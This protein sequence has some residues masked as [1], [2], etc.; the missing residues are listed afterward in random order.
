MRLSR[1]LMTVAL[2]ALGSIGLGAGA[3]AQTYGPELFSQ[4]QWRPIGPLRAGRGRAVAGV[5]SAPNIFYIGN[6]DGGVWKSTDYGNSW[7][8]IF[9]SEPTSSIGAI[10]VADSDPSVIYV[11]TGEGNIR[12]DQT[13]GMGMYK[14]TDAGRTWSFIGLRATQDI[15]MI[16][17]DPH[18]SNRVFVAALGHIYDPNKERGIFR[19]L[20]GGKTWKQVLYVNEYTSGDDIEMDPSNPNI[21]YATLWQQQQAPWENGQFGGTDGGIFKS[22][23]G[24]NTW[25]KLTKGL[26]AVQ[27][28]L[29]RVAPSNPS[30]LYTSVSSGPGAPDGDVGLY[31]SDDAGASWHEVT[32]DPRPAERIG[33]GDLPLLAIDPKNPDVVYSDTP[34]LWKSSD[35]GK[36]WSGFWGAPGGDDYQQT[37]INPNNPDIMAVNSDQGAIVTVD[38]G[39][40]WSSWYN[41]PTAAM[42][43]IGIDE[44]WPYRVCGGQQDSGSACVSERGDDGELT[45][46]DWH[47]AGI[48]E[49]GGAAPDPLHPNLVY[50]GKVTVY[51]RDTGQI[52]DVGPKAMRGG[53][54]RVLRTMPLTF[55]PTDPHRLYFAAN[56]V[57]QTDDG[58]QNWKRISPD[59]TRK[60][61]KVP[62]SLGKYKDSPDAKSTDRGVVYAL[63][64]SPL[65]SDLIWAGTND[66]LIW[67]THDGGQHWSNVTPPQLQPF[68]RVFSMEA[69]RFDPNEAYAAVN[70]LF[71][72][73]MRPHLL[74]TEDGGKHWTEIDN[75][76]TPDAAS[77]VIRQDPERKGLLFA[78]TETQVWM[79]FDN[80][81]H[82]QSLRLNMPAVS[83]R[84][85]K[86][87]GDDLIAATHGR[88]YMVLDDIAPLRQVDAEVAQ[89]PVT[90]YKPETAIRVRWDTN[91]PT[92]WRMPSLPNPPPGAIIDYDLSHNVSG[93]VTLDIMDSSGKLVRHFSSADP[94][95]GL[96]PAKL[97]V[98]DWWPRPPM[99]LATEGGM[100]RFV[101][102][103]HY[104]PMPGALQFLDDNQAVEHNTP[105]VPS[106]PWIMPG[107]YTVRL[108]VN[109]QSHTQPL[110]VKMDPRVQAPEAALQ[111]QLDASM[112]VYHE[113]MAASAALGQVRDL[114]KQIAARKS[115]AKLKSYRK[116][117]E[118]LSGPEA[119]SEFAMFRYQGPPTLASIGGSLQILMGRM[120]GADRAPTAADVAALDQLSSQYKSL[121]SRW[122]KLEG[123]PLAELNRSLRGLSQPSLVLA[124]AVA[125]ADWNAGWITTNRDEEVQ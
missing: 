101:W 77:N 14:S 29:L 28:A 18:D 64:P 50:G 2:T 53:D 16:A 10:A 61:W 107:D 119:T 87:H 48:E 40:T 9:D 20:D 116:Q 35:G 12:P 47:P 25:N 54:Y 46:H 111:Q 17:V 23:D 120:Q 8:P 114:E 75:G 98:P 39:E 118:E 34:V 21:L 73:D 36:T 69:S 51:D 115:S 84:D 65:N 55:S 89:G 113:A 52:A 15:A 121:M 44:T 97:D 31:R 42:Y 72:N 83:V 7:R 123:Q 11:G 59:L 108:T 71:L 95:K 117:L 78:G 62:L 6:D 63:A 56:T 41:Q 125:P 27:Q 45:A 103:M 80:G 122:Q 86:V 43:K 96:D 32:N 94:E 38:G 19:S 37:W 88:G 110:T 104:Q 49:Y 3:H 33:G 67:V 22:T 24:G 81:D 68:W 102:D 4:L 66:G 30:V 5:P 93:P 58:G 90:L 57:W 79:S 100:H 91:P 124:K 26:P 106:S 13:T 76:I 70:T 60:S 105:V 92:P 109:G 112:Q 99:N 74:R 85:L 82:W 1:L